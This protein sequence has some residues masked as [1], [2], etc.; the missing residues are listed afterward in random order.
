M[1]GLLLRDLRRDP[2]RVLGRALIRGRPNDRG[3]RDL[4]KVSRKTMARDPRR[5]LGIMAKIPRR[6]K[7]MA[8]DP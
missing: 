3:T 5:V 4:A 8:V 2:S 6:V 7:T 1:V